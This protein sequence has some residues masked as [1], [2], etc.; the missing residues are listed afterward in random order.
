M[1]K[2]SA[3]RD[4]L[5]VPTW[6]ETL[7]RVYWLAV[8]G[9]VGL[10]LADRLDKAPTLFIGGVIYVFLLK[11]IYWCAG[12]MAPAPHPEEETRGSTEETRDYSADTPPEDVMSRM[13]TKIIPGYRYRG[14]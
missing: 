9:A 1:R 6:G 5:I 13:K 8:G 10:I 4:E 7:L 14:E 12:K 3:I 2:H 11:L